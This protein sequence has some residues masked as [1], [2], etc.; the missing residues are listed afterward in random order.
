MSSSNPLQMFDQLDRL[1]G[2]RTRLTLL[3]ACALISCGKS[4]PKKAPPTQQE[5]S[6]KWHKEWAA[7][8]PRPTLQLVDHIESLLGRVPCVGDLNHWSRSY[9]YDMLPERTV[10]TGIVD[11]HLEEADA[12]N[13]TGRQITAPFSPN[14]DDRRI[15]MGR[16]ATTI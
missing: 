5:L 4:E 10:D 11:F 1:Y 15:K 14:L 8:Q 9:A 12:D 13:K 6:E 3:A 7:R 16:A 2:M